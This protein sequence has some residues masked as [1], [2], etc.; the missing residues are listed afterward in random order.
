MFEFGTWSNILA[1]AVLGN[2]RILLTL[3]SEFSPNPFHILSQDK[4]VGTA[5]AVQIVKW[6]VGINPKNS[7]IDGRAQRRSR[8][9]P[10]STHHLK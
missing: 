2:I 5:G 9:R 8:T 4:K 6:Y 3:S 1:H 7:L 10:L